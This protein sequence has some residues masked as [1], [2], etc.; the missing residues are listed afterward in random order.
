MVLNQLFVS[1]PPLELVNKI[2][3]KFGLK[4]IKDSSEFSILDIIN[5][6]TLVAIKNFEN[7]IQQCYI[8]CKRHKYL[9]TL[10]N[11]SIITVLRQFIKVYDYDLQSREKYINGE[12][13]TIYKIITKHDKKFIKSCNG[14]GIKK[15][16]TIIFD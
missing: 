5:N 16:I 10:D 13:Y 9:A 12:K 4:D 11:K 3:S 8:P 6:N 14:K 2:I 15:E 1:K 7:E